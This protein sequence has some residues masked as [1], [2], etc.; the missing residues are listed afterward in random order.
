MRG[1]IV[2]DPYGVMDARK[3]NAAGLSVHTLGQP[4]LNPDA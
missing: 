3:A 1:R 2:I 4:P